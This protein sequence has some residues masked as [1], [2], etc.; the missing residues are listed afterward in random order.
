MVNTVSRDYTELLT[1]AS[2]GVKEQA[3]R[4]IHACNEVDTTAAGLDTA[5]A[6]TN[7]CDTAAAN[8]DGW[9]TAA[10]NDGD[11]E[12]STAYSYCISDC[13]GIKLTIGTKVL[14]ALV[15][16]SLRD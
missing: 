8:T 3:K 13:D 15:T 10:A 14:N 1:T 5:A 9:D 11:C 6:N 2:Q 4:D 12:W 16:S 7:G